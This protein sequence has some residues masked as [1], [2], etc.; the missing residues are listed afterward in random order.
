MIEIV[1]KPVNTNIQL[2]HTFKDVLPDVDEFFQSETEAGVICTINAFCG[3]VNDLAEKYNTNIDPNIFKGHSLELFSEYLI[4]ANDTDNRIGIYD[5][6][7]IQGDDDY[8]ADGCGIGENGNPAT[9]QV[10]FRRG[11]WVLTA[12]EDHLTN[13]VLRSYTSNGVKMEDKKNMLIITTALKV[14]E[15][16][17]EN[18]LNGAVR[19]LNR[20][21]LRQMLD[22]RI[23]WWMRFW[24]SVKASRIGKKRSLPK[25]ELRQH[26]LEAVELGLNC[27]E[28]NGKI[29]L[30]TGTGK[31]LIEA[32]IIRQTILQK[33]N[34]GGVP[35]IKVNSSRILL[36][37]QL[38]NEI[39]KY[40]NS[41]GI[42]ARYVNYNSGRPDERAYITEMRKK[43][44][45]YR[46]IISTTSFKEVKKVYD[47]C[48]K[49]KIP[50]V[51]LS[52]YHSSVKFSLSEVIP[53][54]TVHDEAHNL[55]SNEFYKAAQ[56][57]TGKNLF[58]TAT[59]KVN[60]CGIGMN[61]EEIYGPIV[62]S[63]SP[64]EMIEAGEMVAPHVHVVRAKR[65]LLVNL[66]KLDRDYDALFRSIADAFFK[67]QIKL[68]ETSYEP[69]KLGGKVLVVCRGQK[70]LLE[71]FETKVFTKFIETYPDIHLFALSSEFGLYNDGEYDNPPVSYSKKSKF[72]DKVRNLG[73]NKKAIIFH[74]DMIGEGI[75]VPGITGVM[76]FRNSELVKFVQNIG[77]ASRL[78][79]EDRKKIYSGRITVED[80]TQWIKPY[81]WV[82]IPTFLENS[83][84]FSD[85]LREIINQLRNDYGYI[86]RQDTFIDNVRGLD[87]DEPIDTVN[88]KD[89]D[90]PHADSG[91]DE[92][93]HEYENI[94]LTERIIFE[95]EVQQAYEKAS[96]ELDNLINF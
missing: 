89:K 34:S 24:E 15:R 70:D 26:Q 95:D 1:E 31:T 13:F 92:F 82:I 30:P 68:N 72:L 77:R 56:L 80:R 69:A 81:S 88:E 10:K 46:E 38:F 60:E 49:E 48:V 62:Y 35:V 54:L 4:K 28:K 86:P 64:R 44:G 75:D 29:I 16:V 74:V 94:T 61:N 63:K 42:T 50:L 45:I 5:Y 57:D 14:D 17:M 79:V 23:E 76:P 51:V 93:E 78:H 12:N 65:G 96:E 87:E 21:S 90:R 39:F 36:C 43:G 19:V 7:P 20:E 91:L 71:M 6:S 2:V 40:L 67:H 52:T 83:E 73:P 11:D 3:R 25:I 41:Y 58:F 9:V 18:M 53:D 22:N 33:L 66:N 47:K 32:D 27:G 8:G 55:V 59:E 37:F 84:G 85:R